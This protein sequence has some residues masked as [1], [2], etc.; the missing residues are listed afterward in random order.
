MESLKRHLPGNL[1]YRPVL[2]DLFISLHTFYFI[3]LAVKTATQYTE[4]SL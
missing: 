2:Q 4:D 3:I 1:I